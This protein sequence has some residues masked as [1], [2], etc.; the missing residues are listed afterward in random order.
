MSLCR[1]L[2]G[3]KEGGEGEPDRPGRPAQREQHSKLEN[4]PP[5]R[6]T[7]RRARNHGTT[8]TNTR[9]NLNNQR[10]PQP[11]PQVENKPNRNTTRKTSHPQD[12]PTPSEKNRNPQDTHQRTAR[13]AQQRDDPNQDP[14]P[15]KQVGGGVKEGSKGS[16]P[17]HLTPAA[18]QA[19]GPT[20]RTPPPTRHP[21]PETQP[22]PETRHQNQNPHHPPI[23]PPLTP[24]QVPCTHA[25]DHQQPTPTLA[26]K[27]EQTPQT[28]SRKSKPQMPGPRP[29]SHPT[30]HYRRGTGRGA[31]VAPPGMRHA[32]NRRRPH[33]RRRQPRT[34]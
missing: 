2:W 7:T 22:Q 25:M 14:Q 29:S 26:N 21:Q 15:A 10:E 11:R 33:R 31:P 5:T 30:T 32:R 4:N 12:Q 18:P 23:T 6:D 20:S 13:T 19:P 16:G 8:P 28:S 34:K 9:P 3:E 24:H 17:P 1:V 27:L